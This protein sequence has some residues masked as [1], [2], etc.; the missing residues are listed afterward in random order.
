MSDLPDPNKYFYVCV[1]CGGGFLDHRL[2]EELPKTDHYF[3]GKCEY[4]IIR[5]ADEDWYKSIDQLE[6]IYLY[7]R[8]IY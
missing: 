3:S 8:E 2:P 1:D 6:E 5:I 4:K 7:P